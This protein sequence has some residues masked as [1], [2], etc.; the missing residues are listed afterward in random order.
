M[1][2]V[3]TIQNGS[4]FPDPKKEGT[5]YW[6]KEHRTYGDEEWEICLWDGWCFKAYGLQGFERKLNFPKEY[7]EIKKPK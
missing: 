3:K 7:V 2:N 5:M 1:A 6:V 4:G